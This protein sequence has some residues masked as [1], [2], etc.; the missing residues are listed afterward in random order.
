MK[1]LTTSILAVVLT[2]SFVMVDAQRVA[3]DT[4][5]T[6]DIEGVVVTALGIKREKKSLGYASQEV[7]A[8]Q[9]TD[10]TTKTGNVASQLSG[11]VA[12]LN[13]TTTNNFGGSANLVI[14]GM[15]SLGGGNPLI[16]IDGSPVNNESRYGSQ[17]DY[18][19]ALSDI[20]QEDIESV[21]VLKGAAASALYGERGL[22]G[23]IVITTKSGRGKED[24]SWG[25]SYSTGVTVGTI[26]KST[27]P[28]YQ[29]QYGGGYLQSFYMEDPDANGINYVNYG[30]DASWGPKFD[31]NLQVWHWDAFD[32]TSPY[33]GQTRPWVAAASPLTDFFETAI[34][35]TNTVTLEKGTKDKNIAFTYDNLNSNG[36][37]PN[38]R[39]NKNTFSLKANYDF[40][41]RLHSSFYSTLTLQDT[42]GRNTTGYSDNIMSGFRQWWQTNVDINEQRDAYFRN[43]AIASA[44][45]YY[46]NISWNRTSSTDGTG[47]YWNNPYFQ[48][49]ENYNSDKRNRSFSY[50]N[51]NYDINDNLNL[52]GK[53]SYDRLNLLIENRLAVGSIAQTFGASGNSVTSGY[54]RQDVT[55]TEVNYDAMLNYKFDITSNI[56]VSGVLGGNVRR[57][58]YNSLYA[59][60]EGGLVVPGIY[61]LANSQE[62]PLAPSETSYITQTNSGYI[63][64][65]FDF[66]KIFYL[67]GTFRVDQ[68]STLPKGNNVYSYP[69]VTGALILSELIK[70]S[71]LNFWK[72]RANYAEVGGTASAYQLANS[73]TSSGIFG[74]SVGNVGIYNTNTTQANADLKPQRSKEFEVGTEIRLFRDRI[75]FDAAYYKTKTLNQIISLPVSASTGY[76]RKVINAGRIDNTGVELQLGLV[77]IKTNDFRWD[78]NVN[79]SKNENKVV[80]LYADS[81]NYQLSSYQGGV[82]LNAYVGKS[83][84][85]LIG[86]DYKYDD[87]GNRILQTYRSGGK[88]YARYVTVS[89]QEIGNA[90]PDWLGGIRN[91][92]NYKG[93]SFS[94]LIDVR[95]GGDVFSTDM[96]YG[97]ATGLYEETAAGD[98]RTNGVVQPGVLTTGEVNTYPQRRP[99]YYGAAGGY[100]V[101]PAKAFVYDGSYVKLREASITYT[102]PKSL[103]NGT[104]VNDAKISIVGRNLWIIH[105]NLPYADPEAMV[106]GGVRAYGWS[107]GSTPTT[108]DLGVNVTL[109]F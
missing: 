100:V 102:L 52:V 74:S 27:F 17:I 79:W 56:D 29:N 19:N 65:S 61:S 85:T 10:G 70:P 76:T 6:Q 107:S 93:L 69:S 66:Y 103:L 25:L 26:D 89:N 62:S 109:K 28:K 64:A 72:L 57:N 23:V 7:K 94:F 41:P 54:A 38:S 16:V 35:Y 1:K 63:T 22:N 33:Y 97:L 32:T 15:K 104:F 43:R 48:L 13:V 98:I 53:V 58:N 95:H 68:S 90:T 78:I 105:K 55:S 51:L 88:T 37:M 36:I 42:R 39:L 96:Y 14:R 106:G 84:G 83:W 8:D 101:E 4:V 24:N 30:E 18:G 47:A 11:K 31:P 67:D 81:Q 86:S 75:T 80:S 71:F 9:L 82:T 20:N 59:S 2:S 44:D 99:D 45:N 5:K 40:N 46:G 108:R 73:Y 60:T 49:Y 87:N 3:R 50:V 77:P 34:T 12:G 21:N 92:I 91:S